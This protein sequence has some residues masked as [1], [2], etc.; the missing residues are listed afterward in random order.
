MWVGEDYVP[1]PYNATFLA[2]STSSSFNFMIIDDNV[3]EY[4]E[5]FSL[6]FNPDLLPFNVIGINNQANVT[7]MDDDGGELADFHKFGIQN[8]L[9]QT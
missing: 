5:E 7:I 8:L 6:I 9:F 3:F 4:T 2:G 1:G